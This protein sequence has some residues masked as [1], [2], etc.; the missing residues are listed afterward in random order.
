M[1][2]YRITEDQYLCLCSLEIRYVLCVSEIFTHWLIS[3]FYEFCALPFSMKTSLP[4]GVVE[5]VHRSFASEGSLY[6][7]LLWL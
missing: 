3:G 1:L 2:F 7:L 5:V 4:S 6:T